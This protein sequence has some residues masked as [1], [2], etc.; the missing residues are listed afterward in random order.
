MALGSHGA[1]VY[2]FDIPRSRERV[3][4]FRGKT[5]EEWQ[6]EV[7]G[8]NVDITFHNLDLLQ[9]SDEDFRRYMSTWLILLDTFHWPDTKLFEREY[10]D[11]LVKMGF[12][13]IL[14]L[15]DIHLNPEM[16]KWWKELQDSAGRLGYI[17]YDVT[18]VGHFS[19]TGLLDF[20]GKVRITD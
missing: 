15:D 19:G 4:A 20:S 13:G 17:A 18:N 16:E 6:K 7:H 9:I 5:E 10:F 1:P 2:T 8:A 11:R 14:L 3:E 12:K